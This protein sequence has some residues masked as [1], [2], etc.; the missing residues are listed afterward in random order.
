MS[1]PSPLGIANIVAEGFGHGCKFFV[2]RQNG[3]TRS[4]ASHVQPKAGFCTSPAQSSTEAGQAPHAGSGAG[5]PRRPPPAPGHRAPLAVGTERKNPSRC[6]Q[7]VREKSRYPSTWK[8]AAKKESE[9]L[10]FP[11][12]CLF[13]R[14]ERFSAFQNFLG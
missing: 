8:R 10:L 5:P 4:A 1:T 14:G 3:Q 7:R 13:A 6:G 11:Q 9:V 12:R 2:F